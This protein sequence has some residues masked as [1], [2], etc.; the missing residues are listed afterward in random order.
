[1]RSSVRSWTDA[2]GPVGH[3]DD[4]LALTACALFGVGG[5]DA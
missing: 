4:V 1:V 5:R 3:V 2:A